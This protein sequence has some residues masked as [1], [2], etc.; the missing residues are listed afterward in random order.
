MRETHDFLFIF[1]VCVRSNLQTCPSRRPLG[2]SGLAKNTLFVSAKTVANQGSY[3]PGQLHR[4]P[5]SSRESSPA[6][7][8]QRGL[9]RITEGTRLGEMSVSSKCQT[10]CLL[11]FTGKLLILRPE[12][13]LEKKYKCK[14]PASPHVHKGHPPT[15][16]GGGGRRDK[17]T[18]KVCGDSVFVDIWFVLPEWISS[19]E[20]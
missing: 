10:C 14:S 18:V 19:C 8:G 4:H 16:H 12:D 2:V 13:I 6:P 1:K 3:S 20:D 7:A 17:E 9:S 11:L 5:F 15:V